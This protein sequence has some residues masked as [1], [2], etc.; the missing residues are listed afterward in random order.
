MA[1]N[2]DQLDDRE[3]PDSADIDSGEDPEEC[4][5]C[6]QPIYGDA[7]RCPYCGHWQV[8][9]SLAEERSR[10]WLWPILIGTLVVL[11]AMGWRIWG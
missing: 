4:E 6:G 9:Q 3:L 1:W 8:G 5:A 2:D 11:G 10:G 7:P